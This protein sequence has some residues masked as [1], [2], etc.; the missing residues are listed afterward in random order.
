M[1]IEFLNFRKNLIYSTTVNLSTIIADLQEI[2]GIDHLAELQQS[3]YAKRAL[4]YFYGIIGCFVLGFIL[5][6]VIAKIPVFVFA[7]FALFLVIIVLTIL[8]IYELVRRFKLGK[9]NILN[10][11]YEVTQRIVQMLARDMDAG[12]EMEIKLSFKR[13][14]NKENLAETIPHPTKR[15]WKIDKYQN[16][17]LKLNGQLLDKTQFL[18]TATEISK[19]QYGWKRGSSGKSKYKTKTNDVG[20]D[21]VLTLHYP[22]RR[23]GAIK[24]LQSEVSKAVKLPNLSHPRNVKLTDKAVHL[25][26]RMAP[27]VADN[28]NEIY[29]TITMMFLSLYQVLNLAKVLS[30]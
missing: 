17:W 2:E 10:Y 23:Y 19:T 30:K 14:K 26:V 27:Q 13:T 4:Y 15:D 7:L 29:Q 5:L 8:I 1:P 22:Q 28:E 18:L 20:L 21:I 3:K 12:S 24:I 11:R 16:E 9:L 25:S 6:F